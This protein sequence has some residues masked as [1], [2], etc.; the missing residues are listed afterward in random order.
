FSTAGARLVAASYP[1]PLVRVSQQ[2]QNQQVS[3]SL[4]GTQSGDPPVG[5][6]F[7]NANSATSAQG[8]RIIGWLKRKD[9][10]ITPQCF[11]EN[12]EFWPVVQRV[13]EKH[14]HED[15]ELVSQAAFQKTGWMNIADGR[16]PP[17][18]GRTADAE[19]ILGCVLVEDKAI[20]PGSFQPN[21][22]HRPVTR[23]GLFQLPKYLHGKLAEAL[24]ES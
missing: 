8:A 12:R 13:L 5:L 14:A 24:S 6:A 20:Q 17:P 15:P 3:S 11:T 18:L 2:D 7:G 21:W 22:A 9:D 23:N 1:Y 10:P 19:D 4:A 16:N